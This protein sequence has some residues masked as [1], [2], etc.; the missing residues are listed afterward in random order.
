[1]AA[2]LLRL[3]PLPSYVVTGG[4]DDL[5][6]IVSNKARAMWKYAYNAVVFKELRRPVSW[7]RCKEYRDARLRWMDY[8][9]T[10]DGDDSS[11]DISM[12]DLLRSF[13]QADLRFW[14][15]VWRYR[16]DTIPQHT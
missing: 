8:W 3:R 5:D 4:D 15:L 11:L 7:K 12:Q 2:E 1:M 14:K 6:S 16:R 13:T 9:T 10:H